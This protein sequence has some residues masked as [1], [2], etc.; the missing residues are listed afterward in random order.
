MGDDA[1][2]GDHTVHTPTIENTISGYS[3]HGNQ[4]ED[5][6]TYGFA[7]EEGIYA[8]GSLKVGDV[9]TLTGGFTLDG[10]TITGVDD[11]GEFTNND[12][13]IMTSAAVED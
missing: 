2:Y 5:L 1:H 9:S 8:G 10:N 4:L 12:A 7:H 11:S 13:H 3:L 6:N